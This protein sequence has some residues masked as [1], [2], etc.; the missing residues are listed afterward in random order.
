MRNKICSKCRV[1]KSLDQFSYARKTANRL[2]SDCKEC[3]AKITKKHYHKHSEKYRERSRSSNKQRKELL[4]KLKQVPCSDC[5]T[6][7][8]PYVMDFDHVRGEKI[9]NL[10]HLILHRGINVVLE[11]VTKCDIVCSNCHRIREHKRRNK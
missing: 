3:C 9:G 5:N 1:S 11:E 2:R 4:N 8:P 10:S 6:I 7:Y